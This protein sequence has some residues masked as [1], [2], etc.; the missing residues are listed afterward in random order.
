MKL[1][2]TEKELFTAYYKPLPVLRGVSL[3]DLYELLDNIEKATENAWLNGNDLLAI[4]FD[5]QAEKVNLYIRMY[6][7]RDKK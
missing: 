5:Q 4:A 7:K 6:E 1:Y 2:N 3:N